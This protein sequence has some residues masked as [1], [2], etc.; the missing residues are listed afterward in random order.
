VLSRAKLRQRLK[1]E[2]IMG[3]QRK[4]AWKVSQFSRRITEELG[5]KKA[6]I[7]GEERSKG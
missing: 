1:K 3:E 5:G 7:M 2:E 6:R 4:R